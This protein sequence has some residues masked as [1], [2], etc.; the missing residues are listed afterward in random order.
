MY[1]VNHDTLSDSFRIWIAWLQPK[2]DSD[3]ISFFKNR[4]GSQKN[5]IRSTLA[6]FFENSQKHPNANGEARGIFNVM[7]TYWPTQDTTFSSLFAVPLQCA[8]SHTHSIPVTVIHWK[9]SLF[10]TMLVV[11]ETSQF[12]KYKFSQSHWLNVSRTETTI[13]LFS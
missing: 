12:T 1:V 2:Q 9:A 8:L 5:T 11:L 3:R 10:R 6:F 7:S 13:G 4:I